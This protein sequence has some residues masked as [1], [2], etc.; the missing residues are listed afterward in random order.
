M[1]FPFVKVTTALFR[2]AIRLF[3]VGADGGVI[4]VTTRSGVCAEYPVFTVYC[5]KFNV[6]EFVFAGTVIVPLPLTVLIVPGKIVQ[7]VPASMLY[8]TFV[9]ELEPLLSFNAPKL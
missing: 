4:I 5:L 6:T 8:Y 3:M 2:P 9:T 7:V 1:V